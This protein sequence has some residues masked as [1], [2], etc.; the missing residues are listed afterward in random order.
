MVHVECSP[1]EQVVLNAGG[2]SQRVEKAKRGELLTSAD[3]TLPPNAPY[4]RIAVYDEYANAAST[5]GF[6]ADEL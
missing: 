3:L 6:F 4:F 1:A 2:K 5:R